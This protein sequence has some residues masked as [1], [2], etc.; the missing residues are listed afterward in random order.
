MHKL[1]VCGGGAPGLE[2]PLIFHIHMEWYDTWDGSQFIG[3]LEV[4][5]TPSFA[6]L[7][8]VAGGQGH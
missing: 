3:L 7:R 1:G 6:K 8:Q 4:Q 2:V 5:S